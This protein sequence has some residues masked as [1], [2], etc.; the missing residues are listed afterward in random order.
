MGDCPGVENLSVWCEG[1]Y[2]PNE[3]AGVL[4]VTSANADEYTVSLL[5]MTGCL[6]GLFPGLGTLKSRRC[7][8]L[9]SLG[10]E[11]LSGSSTMVGVL[12]SEAKARLPMIGLMAD[13]LPLFDRSTLSTVVLGVSGTSKA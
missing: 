10:G 8:I 11:V 2:S 1:E 6:E 5:V 12:S 4:V 13:V 3:S 9:K 7:P